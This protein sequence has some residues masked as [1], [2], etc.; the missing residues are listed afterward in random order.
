MISDEELL[1]ALEENNLEALEE[2][3]DRHHRTALAIAYRVLG[4]QK[5]S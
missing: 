4:D 2:L 1:Q 3:Y 5:L